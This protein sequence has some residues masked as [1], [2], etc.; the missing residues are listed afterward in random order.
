MSYIGRRSSGNWHKV[1]AYFFFGLI[2][3]LLLSRGAFLGGREG[4]K[5][6]HREGKGSAWTREG[7]DFRYAMEVVFLF[8]GLFLII[9]L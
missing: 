1:S 4:D 7:E 5:D 6:M 2:L 9:F 8:L 3:T